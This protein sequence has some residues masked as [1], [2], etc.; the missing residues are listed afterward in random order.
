[1]Y[2]IQL[3]PKLQNASFTLTPNP[4]LVIEHPI[5]RYALCVD[6]LWVGL[7]KYVPPPNPNPN[8]NPHLTLTPNPHLT[9]TLALAFSMWRRNFSDVHSV[10]SQPAKAFA[11]DLGLGLGFRLSFSRAVA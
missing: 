11:C 10:K 8:P 2:S 7:W 1:M 3:K 4:Y 5:I 6:A 9:L